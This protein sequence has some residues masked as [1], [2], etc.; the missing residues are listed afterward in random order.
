MPNNLETRTFQFGIDTDSA[1]SNVENGFSRMLTNCLI[2][3]GVDVTNIKG[4][5][6]VEFEEDFPDFTTFPNYT[7]LCLGSKYDPIFKK[8]YFFVTCTDNNDES[9]IKSNYIF[10]YDVES[11]I[12]YVVCDSDWSRILDF[13]A[14][15]LITGISVV[16][17]NS[18]T[19][20]LYWTQRAGLRKINVYKAK[21]LFSSGGTDP[22]GYSDASIK[23][24]ER[25]K[26]PA[27]FAPQITQLT[28]TGFIGNN[29]QKD[30]FQFS[31]RNI[32]DDYEKSVPSDWSRVNIPYF[33]YE[34]ITND[35]PLFQESQR[36]NVIWITIKKPFEIVEKIEIIVREKTS[37]VGIEV[38]YDWR[39]YDTLTVSDITWNEDDEYV[40]KFYNDKIGELITQEQANRIFDNVPL[41]AVAETFAEDSRVYEANIT[42]GFDLEPIDVDVSHTATPF[43]DVTD[44][45]YIDLFVN[46]ELPFSPPVN[47]GTGVLPNAP[48]DMQVGGTISFQFDVASIPAINGEY[49]F[50]YILTEADLE[51]DNYPTLLL[52]N[53]QVAFNNFIPPNL[54][55]YLTFIIADDIDP[56]TF[57]IEDGYS[58]MGSPIGDELISAFY[59]FDNNCLPQFKNRHIHYLGIG[60]GDDGGRRSSVQKI[61]KYYLSDDLE[62]VLKLRYTIN[63]VPPIWAT[64]YYIYYAGFDAGNYYQTR[65]SAVGGLLDD[66]TRACTVDW[67][68]T[69]Y[70]FNDIT[71]LQYQY[72]EGDR[73]KFLFASTDGELDDI[74]DLAILY[75][76]ETST[77]VNVENSSWLTSALETNS[78]FIVEI[79]KK[80]AQTELY[81]TID[82]NDIGD[83]GLPT[84]YHKGNIQDQDAYSSPNPA[85]QE[86]SGVNTYIRPRYMQDNYIQNVYLLNDWAD[87]I[88]SY[89]NTGST[90]FIS[91]LYIY[92]DVDMTHLIATFERTV[93]MVIPPPPYETQLNDELIL[94]LNESTATCWVANDPS[95]T[96]FYFLNNFDCSMNA[97]YDITIAQRLSSNAPKLYFQAYATGNNTTDSV[98][99]NGIYVQNPSGTSEIKYIEDPNQSDLYVG[100]STG[101]GSSISGSA[102]T[103]FGKPNIVNDNF[104]QVTRENTVWYSEQLIPE[105]NIN[106]LSSFP[107]GQF[108][109][110]SQSFGSIQKLFSTNRMLKV[111]MELRCGFLPINQYLT[112]G[113][114]ANLVLNNSQVLTPMNYYEGF[115]GVGKCP[116]SHAHFGFADYFVDPNN[117]AVCR[118]SNDGLTV[119]SDV[120]NSQGNYLVR[121]YL[122]SLVKSNTGN[123]VATFN[124]RR[125]SYEVNIGGC[126]VVWNEEK[127]QWHGTRS[128]DGEMFGSAGVDMISFSNG[129]LYLHEANPVYNNFYGRQYTSKVRA[130]SN[131]GLNNKVYKAIRTWSTSNWGAPFI[132]NNKGQ[133]S[134]LDKF[135]FSVR[136]GKWYASFKMDMNTVNVQYP[137]IN[138]NVLRDNVLLV[139]LENDNIEK[140]SLKY[141][142]FLHIPS[143]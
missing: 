16:F 77:I 74:I 34:V 29:I 101:D 70:K 28:D 20:L 58:P 73:I 141:V 118:L 84:R 47:G 69:Q 7:Y 87:F 2:E 124:Q 106:G 85:I 79:Y 81:Y 64:Q 110:Y 90:S 43:L 52:T 96:Q 139:E 66:N 38:N 116:E 26:Y 104:R 45:E 48:T 127:N 75:A 140:E 41:A 56:Y 112:G 108:K 32:Y 114:G 6:K 12:V 109:D 136:E 135:N 42:E 53:M 103:S 44:A 31:T 14:D 60:Y 5:L 40:Y 55:A 138:G 37:N 21:L 94:Y 128:Y 115:Y 132:A 80:A 65:V 57:Y 100:I 133:R 33:P 10:E 4:N 22:L 35:V 82:K 107:D 119:I 9:P 27:S 39:I 120:K 117:G 134:I 71:Y 86:F 105:S 62:N 46:Q 92:S 98:S 30:F 125:N 68:Q 93:P 131:E 51:P 113:D 25:I 11:R 97:F 142:E 63:H 13:D 121:Q 91:R 126:V 95:Y 123:F 89:T 1:L 59:K 88:A 137:I 8:V 54:A 36:N 24:I 19:P 102:V 83:V 72:S 17:I 130:V 78:S 129:Q 67:L 3:N 143:K 23:I 49:N 50:Q 18:T 99:E 76:N 111:F 122:Y 61:S 15:E